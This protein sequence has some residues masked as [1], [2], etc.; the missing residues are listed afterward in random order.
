MKSKIFSAF[1]VIAVMLSSYVHSQDT[2]SR[3]HADNYT[4]SM[5]GKMDAE[6]YHG[7]EIEHLALGFAGGI[8]GFVGATLS[9]PSPYKDPKTILLSPNKGLFNDPQYFASYQNKAR[10]KNINYTAIGWA[11]GTVA[12]VGLFILAINA[13]GGGR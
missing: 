13:L 11:V 8:Y 10:Q 6:K 7:K 4:N 3:T 12:K 2:I 1:T 9:N 5:K